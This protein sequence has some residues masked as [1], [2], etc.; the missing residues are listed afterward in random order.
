MDV[1]FSKSVLNVILGC[2]LAVLPLLNI[3]ADEIPRGH[4]TLTGAQV[5]PIERSVKDGVVNDH[6]SDILTHWIRFDV[7]AKF[8]IVDGTETMPFQITNPTD[9]SKCRLTVDKPIYYY[10][11]KVPAGTNLMKYQRFDGTRYNVSMPP[12]NPLVINSIRISDG[13]TFAPGT[14][15]LCFSW[16]TEDHT[17]FSD[18]VAV[19]IDLEH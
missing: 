19:H 10:G 11:E 17:T 3:I 16:G 14:Y 5:F 13:F 18:S 7:H 6:V 1:R 2:S 9:R 4:Y 8:V 15:R 12:L